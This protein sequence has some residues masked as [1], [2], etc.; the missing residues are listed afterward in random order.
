MATIQDYLNN[1]LKAVYGKDVRQSIHDA[2]KQC[3][4]DVTSPEL[5]IE[6]F[7]AA[8]QNKIDSGELAEMT[9]GDKSVTSEKIADE[10]ITTDSIANG[11]VTV[12]KLGEEVVMLSEDDEDS[13]YDLVVEELQ[14]AASGTEN[15]FQLSDYPQ[16][17]INGY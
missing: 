5:N 9:L 15:T 2:I 6:A 7:E 4:E 14:A 17:F 13:P 12:E 10:A 3:Y 8:V 1:I 16:W 11:S